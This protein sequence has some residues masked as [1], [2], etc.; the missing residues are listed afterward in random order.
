[1]NRREADKHPLLG[2]SLLAKHDTWLTKVPLEHS[3]LLPEE[4]LF[5]SRG[6]AWEWSQI[7]VTAGEHLRE[8][9]LVANP[10]TAWYFYAPHWKVINDEEQKTSYNPNHHI[11]LNAP[12]IK[13][14]SDEDKTYFS[15]ACFTLVDTLECS[16]V[17]G[18]EYIDLVLEN[19]EPTEAWVQLKTLDQCGL[20][21]EFR[22]DGDWGDIEELL[23]SGVPVPMGILHHGPFENPTGTGHWIVAVGVTKDRECLIVHDPLG[24]LDLVEGVYASEHGAFQKY[25]KH[26]LASRWMVEK[27]YSSG[28]YIK[29]KP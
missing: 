10:N 2:Q 14:L 13:N 8:V 16:D 28:W 9:R 7:I 17:S 18:E 4:K 22:Q 15:S 20:H 26:Y 19:G 23:F 11:Q 6:S 29:V 24:D 5:V 27:G 3:E 1:M 21:A 12:Y 25:S